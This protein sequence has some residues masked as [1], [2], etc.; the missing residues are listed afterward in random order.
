MR[1]L[2]CTLLLTVA[3]TAWAQS[4]GVTEKSVD[5]YLPKTALRFAL[6]I[7]KTTFKSGPFT[8]Y[9]DRF[10]P[11]VPL[12]GTDGNTQ[13]QIVNLGLSQ[14]G[15]IDDSQLY[16]VKL[17]GKSVGADIRL[18]DAG[19]LLAINA[20]P[21]TDMEPKPPFQP[22]PRVHKHDGFYYL[23]AKLSDGEDDIMLAQKAVDRI[24]V[25]QEKLRKLRRNEPVELAA[26]ENIE[27]LE[28]EN[29]AL[30]ALFLGSE[31]SDTTEQVVV[32]V[33]EREVQREVMFRLDPHTGKVS[34]TATTGIPYYMTVEDTHSYPKPKYELPSNKREG[35]FFVKVPG[36]IKVTI[37]REDAFIASFP[38]YAAQF[39]FIEELSGSLFK[40]YKVSMVVNPVTGSVDRIR[41]E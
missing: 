34:T 33:P 3:A 18:S 40:N 16:S 21:R 15:L 11:G 9:A 38:V 17:R 41:N 26:G 19:Q 22:A 24:I 10:F 1:N 25:V 7:E 35:C 37:H 29:K 8:K 13:Y 32:I 20:E 12:L 28:D 30:T 23:K 39:G 4:P 31:E 36:K 27:Y 2:L 6:L 5:Y 14:I